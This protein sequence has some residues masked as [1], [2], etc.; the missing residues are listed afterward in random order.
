MV[1][2]LVVDGKRCWH[3]V[4]VAVAAH[5]AMAVPI[6]GLQVVADLQGVAR[7]GLTGVARFTL[8][9]V[10][11]ETLCRRNHKNG[12]KLT[13]HISRIHIGNAFQHKHQNVQYIEVREHNPQENRHN[14]HRGKHSVVRHFMGEY[15]VKSKNVQN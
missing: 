6:L 8:Q 2:L 1:F 14:H 5:G 11:L 9:L 15:G 13:E 3:V 4:A 10:V 12:I 7:Q